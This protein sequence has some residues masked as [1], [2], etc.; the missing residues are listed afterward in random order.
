MNAADSSPEVEE[1]DRRFRLWMRGN[2][3]R[4]AHHF[5][6]TTAAAPAFGW[7]LRSIGAPA[8]GADGPVWLRVVSE[9]LRWARGHAWTGNAEANALS[10]LPKPRLLDSYEWDEGDWRRQRAEVLTLLPGTPCSATPE[11][12]PG[13]DPPAP[14]WAALRYALSRLA[15]MSTDRVSID[16]EKVDQRI[17]DAFGPVPQI[18]IERW[19]TVHADLHWANLLNDPLGILDWEQWG[20]GPAGIDA[21]TLHC[22]SLAVPALSRTIR[23]HFPVLETPDGRR[24]QLYAAAR[25]LNRTRFG[26]HPH[27]IEPLQRHGRRLL[28][29]LSSRP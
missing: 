10:G 20:R 22:Y 8:D 3:E 24:A 16:Q 25:L 6:V 4:A 9:E 27:L 19:E 18:R 21:A 1:A 5:D 23:G 26:D 11:A 12:H 17:R 15:G 7:L 29:L 2:L 28:S 13:I 14:W